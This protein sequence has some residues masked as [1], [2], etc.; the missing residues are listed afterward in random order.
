MPSV[1]PALLV[2]LAAAAPA[3]DQ[4][5]DSAWREGRLP[6]S[7]YQGEPR[8]G[9]ALVVR[10]DQEPPSLDKLTDAA[11]AIDWILERKV[12]ESMAELDASKHPDYSL[13]PALAT[14][15]SV[16]SDQL[17]F[18]FHIRRGVRW[19]DGVPFTGK[20][21]VATV[22]KILDPSVRAMH[23]RNN[24]VD[25]ADISTAPGDDFT[26]IARY[27]K[28]YFLALRALATLQ[29]YP[30][31]LLQTAGDMLHSKVHRAPVGTGPF[32]FEEW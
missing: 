16:S 28:P 4:P 26:V 7:V 13:K 10:L 23:L 22:R 9:G 12:L 29:I 24:F 30:A 31:H 21:V 15:W 8:R 1:V 5:P 20:D 17:T 2:A 27:R 14:D 11:L 25:L 3:G 18:V 6:E 19:H 32:R